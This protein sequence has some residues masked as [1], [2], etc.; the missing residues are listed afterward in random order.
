MRKE[1][2]R[3]SFI[4]GSLAAG[5]LAST[6]AVLGGCS[7]E[8][9]ETKSSDATQ[10]KATYTPSETKDVDVVICG[11]GISGLAA[12]VQ[13][14]EFGLST[15]VVEKMPEVGGNGVGVE[16]IFAVGSSAQKSQNI[17]I[18]PGEL[19]RHEIEFSQY[20][21]DGALWS[22]LVAASAE[23]YDWLVSKGV[24]FSGLINSYGG[25]FETMHWFEGGNAGTGYVPYMSQEAESTGVE[26]MSSASVVDLISEN[27]AI[28]GV[29][30][31][32]DDK[33]IVQVNAKAVVIAT[34]GFGGNLELVAKAGWR[35]DHLKYIGTPGHDGDGVIMAAAVGAKSM[36]ADSCS[37][38]GAG[39]DG[40]SA[41]D[42][43]NMAICFG[44][45]FLWINEEAKRCV[46]E[47]LAG[48]NM[49]NVALPLQE[50]KEVWCIAN[51]AIITA[52]ISGFSNDAA[53]A[54]EKTPE[55]TIASVIEMCPSQNIFKT[56]SLDDL[57]R[58]MNMDAADL[59]AAV[60]SY[61]ECCKA[62]TDT[63]FGKNA[64]F[65]IAIENGPYYGYRLD[66]NFQVAI[67]GICTNR[68]MQVVD[69][70]RE[71]IEG[72]YAVGVDGCMLYRN[73]Y[74][75]NVAGSCCANNVNSGRTAIQH[76]K[77]HLQ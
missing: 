66:P 45:P 73:V 77:A 28:C 61:N 70:K 31:Q 32:A 64:E 20:R 67:G 19:I 75:I 27:N 7:K 22:N 15:L 4:L 1:C 13:A 33:S 50:N 43:V 35:T 12:A 47:D 49:M 10:E 62:G 23:N 65:M 51:D 63:Q 72:L 55:E 52:A 29:Y 53:K 74:P 68:N 8:Q 3:R 60:D 71:P 41:Q 58:S 69:D 14:G 16:G 18:N 76:I 46:N 38:T 39:I 42:S 48:A 40:L 5:A 44:G 59:K 2:S 30:V 34:G 24:R 57:A 36:V 11:G 21:P 6:S 54:S 37:L 25:L 9:G 17:E 26:I 56:D